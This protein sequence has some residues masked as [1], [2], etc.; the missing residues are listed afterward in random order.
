[1]KT[2]KSN[3]LL[4]VTLA[5]MVLA[6][7]SLIISFTVNPDG[8]HFGIGNLI[9]I[10]AVVLVVSIFT[11]REQW[12]CEKCTYDQNH[13]KWVRSSKSLVRKSLVSKSEPHIEKGTRTEYATTTHKDKYGEVIGDSETEYQVK[14][15]DWVWVEKWELSFQCPAC[16]SVYK[17]IQ[18]LDQ[19]ADAD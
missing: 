12:L 11:G 14:Y 16:K 6:V 2:R 19:R 9:L 17:V 8:E 3:P 1:M 18:R 13:S 4:K 5:S 10:L 15:K 7:I